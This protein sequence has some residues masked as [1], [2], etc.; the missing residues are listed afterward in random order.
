MAVEG[1]SFKIDF[2][3]EIAS[4]KP[5]LALEK[6]DLRKYATIYLLN[7]PDFTPKQVK[8]LESYVND[9]GGV[10]FF[11]GPLVSL[12]LYNK[13][14]YKAGKGIFP[15]PLKELYPARELPALEKKGGDSYDLLI[16]D[17]KFGSMDQVPIFGEFLKEPS[18][19]MPL[20]D[21]PIR[22]YFKV[23]RNAWSSR[24]KAREVVA[25]ITGKG[26]ELG[27]PWLE[28]QIEGE[29]KANRYKLEGPLAR[30]DIARLAIGSRHSWVLLDDGISGMD[31]PTTGKQMADPIF[32]LATLPNE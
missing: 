26:L 30:L 21:L 10:A 32:E 5:A 7:V 27:Q 4:G 17:D 28:L 9:G 24:K 1:R 13:E 18:H 6:V 16:R 2:G 14:L 23:D 3:H 20:Q 8:A 22:R 29:E 15:A 12:D 19:R 11:L 31:A 25:T